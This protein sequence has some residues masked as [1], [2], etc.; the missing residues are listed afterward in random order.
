MYYIESKFKT[1]VMIGMVGTAGFIYFFNN[2]DNP[3]NFDV[4]KT[5]VKNGFALS[6]KTFRNF[7]VYPPILC[8]GCSE[9]NQH[10]MRD[11][12]NARQ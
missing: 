6:W 1:R 11:S 5:F 10:L 12:D 8:N 2:P 9:S 3:D 4:A 7:F